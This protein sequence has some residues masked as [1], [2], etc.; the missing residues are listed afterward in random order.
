MRAHQK[1]LLY[2]YE[3]TVY[4]ADNKD[5]DALNK[6][7]GWPPHSQTYEEDDECAWDEGK[8]EEKTEA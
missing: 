2:F 4:G 3:E 7:L 5:S 1:V 8:K 6:I